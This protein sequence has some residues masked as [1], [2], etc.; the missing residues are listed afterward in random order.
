MP[1]TKKR[2]RSPE[3]DGQPSRRQ[4][5][6]PLKRTRWRGPKD[7]RIMALRK[8]ERKRRSKVFEYT[9][10]MPII[11]PVHQPNTPIRDTTPV[12]G[13]SPFQNAPPRA[14]LHSPPSLPAGVD[15][16]G[17]VGFNGSPVSPHVPLESGVCTGSSVRDNRTLF[18]QTQHLDNHIPAW[19]QRRNNQATQ[20]RLVTIPR[21]IPTYLA[22]RAAT[23]SGRLPSLP[24]PNR[25]CQCDTIALKVEMMT[26]DRKSSLHLLQLFAKS[27]PHQNSRHIHCISVTAI[28]LV[29]S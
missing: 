12:S 27:V 28:R 6:S 26:W 21:L 14:V 1:P 9:T 10:N 4:S 22:N 24:L 7:D 19:N 13:E 2:A 15:D 5:T 3:V 25:Q 18:R 16:N 23:K 20:W 8:L 11:A 17:L 29:S